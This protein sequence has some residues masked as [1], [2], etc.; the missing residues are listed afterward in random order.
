MGTPKQKAPVDNNNSLHG[1]STSH[2]SV[3]IMMY[4]CPAPSLIFF[5]GS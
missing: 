1:Y 4:F 5:R 2:L 3:Y